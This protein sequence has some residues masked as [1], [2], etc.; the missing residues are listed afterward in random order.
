MSKH[1]LKISIDVD[2]RVLAASVAG[3]VDSW[4][5]IHD[6][7]DAWSDGVITDGEIIDYTAKT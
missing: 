7:V 4:S 2:D 3:P 6:I 1:E 5:S